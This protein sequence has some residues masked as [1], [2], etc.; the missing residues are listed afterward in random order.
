MTASCGEVLGIDEEAIVFEWNFLRGFTSLEIL[1]K[2]QNDVRQRNIEPAKFTDRIILM[3]MFNDI[4]W[5]K[6]GNDRILLTLYMLRPF[7]NFL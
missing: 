2:I 4:D 7:V 5:I 1:Q 6:K 3:S